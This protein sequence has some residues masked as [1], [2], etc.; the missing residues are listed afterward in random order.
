MF[1]MRAH[2]HVYVTS[3]YYVHTYDM[4]V[5]IDRYLLYMGTFAHKYTYIH[6]NLLYIPYIYTFIHTYIHT[7]K[8]TYI[9]TYMHTYIHAYIHTFG[10]HVT[11]S[12]CVPCVH[13]TPQVRTPDHL[14][15]PKV[16][17]LKL[18]E[19][20]VEDQVSTLDIAVHDDWVAV[21]QEFEGVHHV[22]DP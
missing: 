16:C 11:L 17:K 13:L 20:L 9:H 22:H 3:A 19:L 12:A 18:G 1:V 10:C 14:A 2:I 15:H 6:W 8:H 5:Y 4:R 7:C 21:V